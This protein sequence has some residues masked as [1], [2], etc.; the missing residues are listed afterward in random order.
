MQIS[1]L[2]LLLAS[3]FSPLIYSMNQSKEINP[4]KTINSQRK[5]SKK[6]KEK[7]QKKKG[8]E[9]LFAHYIKKNEG[10]QKAPVLTKQNTHKKKTKKK[11]IKKIEAL[12]V[13]KIASEN[14]ISLQDDGVL[15]RKVTDN[16]HVNHLAIDAN[17]LHALNRLEKNGHEQMATALL[18]TAANVITLE[19][20]QQVSR[21]I[22]N[23][24]TDPELVVQPKDELDL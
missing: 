1:L 6:D 3:S 24:L 5:M 20:L 15:L 12:Q 17:L 13:P 8:E 23:I 10:C 21:T 11:E 7:L 2:I 9:E 18:R 14:D 16:D 22:K 4:E 19:D